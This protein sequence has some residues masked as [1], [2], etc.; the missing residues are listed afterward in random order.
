MGLGKTFRKWIGAAES[1]AL[2]ATADQLSETRKR[3]KE[4]EALAKAAT[5]RLEE[6]SETVAV[7]EK[8][9][10][11]AEASGTVEAFGWIADHSPESALSDLAAAVVDYAKARRL[12]T[13]ATFI[14]DGGE[15]FAGALTTADP[16]WST[17]GGS[18]AGLC[19]LGD[20]SAEGFEAA[21]RTALAPGALA[22]GALLHVPSPRHAGLLNPLLASL[23]GDP[24]HW[25]PWR[26]S[27]TGGAWLIVWRDT[28][29]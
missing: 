25:M 11:F 3:L 17:T 7:L 26:L 20:L 29:A 5:K 6:L 16:E 8:R 19:H 22:S 1:R 23:P 28:H 21:L 15:A 10:E 18:P 14:G 27:S 9:L 4:A 24:P 13:V 12:P 2:Q